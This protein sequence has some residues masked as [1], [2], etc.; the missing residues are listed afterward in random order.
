M[1]VDLAYGRTGLT[2]TLRDEN[3]DIVEPVDLPGVAD[4]LVALR[5]SLCQP[6]GTRPLSELAG[7]ED[8]VAI[9]F[10]DIT[11]PAPNHLMVP[12]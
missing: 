9:V 7:A 11:R 10:C 6:I 3:V 12:A 8:T 1:Q 5:E 2:V 4:P